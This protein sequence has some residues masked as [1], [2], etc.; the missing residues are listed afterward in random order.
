MH[1]KKLCHLTPQAKKLPKLVFD[2]KLKK[3]LFTPQTYLGQKKIF[4]QFFCF[5][6]PAFNHRAWTN[7]SP[8]SIFF[9]S[10]FSAF[11]FSPMIIF[12]EAYFWVFN[13]YTAF[14]AKVWP[15]QPGPTQVPG[16]FELSC[17]LNNI[18]KSACSPHTRLT[19][20]LDRL[21]LTTLT[22]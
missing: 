8:W 9:L 16:V 11:C 17:W 18:L 10:L 20:P 4:G 14:T 21:P 6:Q 22:G 2:L 3:N 7:P 19:K 12:T 5:L 15:R 13:V 1:K